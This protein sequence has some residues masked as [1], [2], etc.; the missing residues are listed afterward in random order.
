MMVFNIGISSSGGLFSGSMFNFWGCKF[1]KFD[2]S[3][4]R[5]RSQEYT[6]E[7]PQSDVCGACA[8]RANDP[9]VKVMFGRREIFSRWWFQMFVISTPTWGNDPTLTIIFQM[10]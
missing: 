2:T 1:G 5:S 10:G 8:V 3:P 7:Q 6:I 9:F 4:P